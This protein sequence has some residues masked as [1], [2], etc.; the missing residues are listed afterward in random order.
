LAWVYR[1]E[2]GAERKPNYWGLEEEGLNFQA[3]WKRKKEGGV[4]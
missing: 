4:K 2:R 3:P 1:E